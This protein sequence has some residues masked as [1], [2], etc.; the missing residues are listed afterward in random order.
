MKKYLFFI[1]EGKNDKIEIQAI[2]RAAGGEK[3]LDSYYD[4]YHVH[5]GDITTEKDTNEKTIVKKLNEI[6]IDWRNGRA[7]PFIRISTADVEKIIHVVDMDGVFIP[8][9][10]IVQTDDAKVQYQEKSIRYFSREQIVGRNRKKA[11]VIRRLIDVK[12]IDNIPYELF[13]AS[14]NMDHLLFDARNPFADVKGRN[15]RVFASR[16]KDKNYLK[17]SIFAENICA[18][19]SYQ[20]SWQMIQKDYNSIERHTNM[21]LMLE[22]VTEKCFL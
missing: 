16:C 21:N 13:F 12:Q 22:D 7:E 9:D 17:D 10:A 3:F 19:G 18:N 8:E 1:V 4:T 2:L 5:N 14:C 11:K 15:A 6:V 20:E